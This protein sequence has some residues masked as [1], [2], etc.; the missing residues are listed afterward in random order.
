MNPSWGAVA[1]A[2]SPFMTEYGYQY[3]G[4]EGEATLLNSVSDK[5]FF[6]MNGGSTPNL[7]AAESHDP[8]S[9]WGFVL[10]DPV[11]GKPCPTEYGWADWRI[12]TTQNS[13]KGFET[14]RWTE[15]GNDKVGGN[16]CTLMYKFEVPENMPV[17]ISSVR[18]D[19]KIGTEI[20][21]LMRA[22]TIWRI[23]RITVIRIP[24]K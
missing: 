19:L 21:G 23:R 3:R 24:P 7:E 12:S 18:E 15:S 13:N 14:V 8:D 1:A 16:P 9:R 6:D 5:P 11:T 10:G 20:F 17:N 2:V 22:S 4:T